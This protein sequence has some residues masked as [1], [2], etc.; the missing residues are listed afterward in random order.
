[1]CEGKSCVEKLLQNRRSTRR[2]HVFSCD[3]CCACPPGTTQPLHPSHL[4][5]TSTDALSYP[6]VTDVKKSHGTFS[7]AVCAHYF[8]VGPDLMCTSTDEKLRAGGG[9]LFLGS[10][11]AAEALM[12]RPARLRHYQNT[13]LLIP[14]MTSF[15][16]PLPD[17]GPQR[18]ANG[19]APWQLCRHCC[20]G[21][22]SAAAVAS[23]HSLFNP[24]P[25]FMKLIPIWP[26]GFFESSC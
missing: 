24:P 23:A 6:Y 3:A 2:Q 4:Q 16:T 18:T 12:R 26:A 7:I 8:W 14:L 11:A 15:R 10:L 20:R 1:M 22:A 19:L 25:V 17:P 9:L 5:S 21:N 13:K